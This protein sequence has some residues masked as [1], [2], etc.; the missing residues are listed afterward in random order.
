M[1]LI[2]G[3]LKG[4]DK[5]RMTYNFTM[6]HSDKE[7]VINFEISNAALTDLSGSRASIQSKE[8][9]FLQH[10]DR[11]EQVAV[12]LFLLHPGKAIV[13]FSKHFKN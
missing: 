3:D 5:K 2:R 6:L 12:A 4:Y 10:R 1:S 13:L 11:I 9:Q 8:E 7:T